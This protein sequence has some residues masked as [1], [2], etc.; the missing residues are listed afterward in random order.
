VLAPGANCT[1]TVKYAPTVAAQGATLTASGVS[2]ALL[3]TAL[4]SGVL[5]I[6]PASIDLAPQASQVFL[7]TNTGAVNTGIL[8][9]G[10]TTS[11]GAVFAANVG[12]CAGFD[13]GPGEPCTISVQFNPTDATPKAATLFAMATPGGTVT[14]QITGTGPATAPWLV[15]GPG[16]HDFGQLMA[17]NTGNF[18]FTVTNF[19]GGTTAALT[20]TVVTQLGEFSVAKGQA[21]D[22]DGATLAAGASCSV[23]VVATPSNIVSGMA[24]GTITLSGN[25]GGSTSAAVSMTMSH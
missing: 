6:A 11:D 24:I 1:I 4:A 7:V 22:C 2:V 9:A 20:S 16:S 12:D 19:G 13:L 25:P 17:P 23:R 18:T 8:A 14:A 15:L 21:G 10:M 3:G 5:T